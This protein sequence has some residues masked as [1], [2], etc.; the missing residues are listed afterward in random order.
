NPNRRWN[1]GLALRDVIAF[2]LIREAQDG[3]LRAADNA[4][5]FW[6]E[7]LQATEDDS[8]LGP[9]KSASEGAERDREWPSI[10]ATSNG[11]VQAVEDTR[12]STRLEG[13]R[14]Q[15][16]Q[17]RGKTAYVAAGQ[18]FLAESQFLAGLPAAKAVF[19]DPRQ[20]HWNPRNLLGSDSPVDRYV[21]VKAL[22]V[23]G[24]THDFAAISNI[25]EHDPEGRV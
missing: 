7:N 13:G 2:I 4:E 3:T 25:A 16:Y 9:P 19:P 6:V 22:G 12:I 10:V 17:L 20:A 23:I 8:K 5:L 11:V 15:T 24:G 21:A 18:P 1:T 14:N